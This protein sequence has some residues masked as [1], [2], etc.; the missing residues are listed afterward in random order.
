MQNMNTTY[1]VQTTYNFQPPTYTTPSPAF[2]K[3]TTTPLAVLGMPGEIRSYRSIYQSGDT[4]FYKKVLLNN[5]MASQQ[6]F[7]TQMKKEGDANETALDV[8]AQRLER[9]EKQLNIQA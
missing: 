8:I 6:E 2:M 7:A 3:L 4:G 1:P 9:I 5:Q